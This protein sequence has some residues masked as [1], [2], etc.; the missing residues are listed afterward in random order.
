MFSHDLGI[1][2]TIEITIDIVNKRT[3]DDRRNDQDD[4]FQDLTISFLFMVMI[5]C[6]S[7]LDSSAVDSVYKEHKDQR[8][9]NTC[10]RSH[11]RT[12]CSPFC[13]TS[14]TAVCK[15]FDKHPCS[16]QADCR[17]KDLFQDL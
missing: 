13:D 5:S 12:G 14:I 4:Q 9:Y 1:Q 2:D 10:S 7:S 8:S 6:H 16:D 15:I 11:S 17:I 3:Q